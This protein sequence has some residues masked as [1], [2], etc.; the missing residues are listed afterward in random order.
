MTDDAIHLIAPLP[1]VQALGAWRIDIAG[2]AAR[3]AASMAPVAQGTGH[4]RAPAARL[5][6]LGGAQARLQVPAARMAITGTVAQVLRAHVAAPLPSVSASATAGGALRG[7]LRLPSAS[8]TARGGAAPVRLL[9]PAGSV[10]AGVMAGTILTARLSGPRARVQASGTAH[11][12][13]FARL[14]VPAWRATPS[15]RAQLLAPRAQ[16]AASGA[17]ATLAAWESYAVNLRSSIEG[18]GSEVT[19]YTA[20]PF[21]AVVRAHGGYLGASSAGLFR[22]EGDTDAGAAIVWSF[23]TALT[24][25]DMPQ[26]KRVASGYL[27]GRLSPTSTFTVQ[28]G[29]RADNTYQHRTPRGATAQNY[30]CPFGRGMNE[31]YYAFGVAGYGPLEVDGMEF[32]VLLGQRRI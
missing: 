25:F 8:N 2:G 3:V 24:D 27:S 22:L 21:F 4:M 7:A 13:S 18:G 10:Q 14:T 1:A 12:L 31:R 32:E 6:A 20:F 19:H 28:A 23:A 5:L 16:V 15:L 9:A 30:R 29:E 26:K 11:A 17:L